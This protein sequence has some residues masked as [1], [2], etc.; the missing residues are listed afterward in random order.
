MAA[1]R[2]LTS[3]DSKFLVILFSFFDQT[4]AVSILEVLR[5]WIHA[6]VRI[7]KDFTSSSSL[8]SW[9]VMTRGEFGPIYG[10]MFAS[11]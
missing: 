3:N 5:S 6:L 1:D 10:T 11:S 4:S 9:P 2:R 7:S 8:S